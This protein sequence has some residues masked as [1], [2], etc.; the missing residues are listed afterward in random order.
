MVD[1]FSSL[2]F[3]PLLHLLHLPQ[4]FLPPDPKKKRPFRQKRERERGRTCSSAAHVSA[5]HVKQYQ[6]KEEENPTNNALL[7]INFRLS[8][9][10]EIF[11]NEHRLS[12][13]I[14]AKRAK[15]VHAMC[16]Y[17]DW[18]SMLHTIFGG[19]EE[20]EEKREKVCLHQSNW[21]CLE[22]SSDFTMQID[23]NRRAKGVFYSLGG[24]KPN[25]QQRCAKWKLSWSMHTLHTHF[26]HVR[27]RFTCSVGAY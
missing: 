10:A 26:L 19:W 21:L 23:N 8:S 22:N 5:A 9:D 4:S 6:G 27:R 18:A 16:I 11:A 14:G 20:E 7:L 25:H 1:L 15:N 12:T 24:S 2:C 3:S 17:S 13:Q